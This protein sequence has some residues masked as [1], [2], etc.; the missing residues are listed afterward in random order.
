MQN[1]TAAGAEERQ[2]AESQISREDFKK[3]IESLLF[4]TD[5]PLSLARISQTAEVNNTALARE[6]IEELRQDYAATGRAVQLVE[7]GGGWQMSTKPEYGRWVRKLFNEK[8]SAKLSPA[9]LET[10][11]IIAYKQPVTRAEIEAIRGVDIVAPLERVMERGLARIVGKKDTPGKPMVYGT[12]EE[13][14]RVFGLNKISELPEIA[15]FAAKG[16]REA[17]GDLPFSDALPD[18]KENI[19]PLTEEETPAHNYACRRRGAETA[20]EEELSLEVPAAAP[21]EA[22][23][24]GESRAADA[25]EIPTDAGQGEVVPGS[26]EEIDALK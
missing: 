15:A 26:M 23:A 9:A 12:T 13:F 2:P 4:I 11:A 21:D 25:Q 5:R 6:I 22:A 1:E 18:I 10:L 14:L 3:I 19:I 16:L 7:I 8:M 17:Q 24:A 20:A